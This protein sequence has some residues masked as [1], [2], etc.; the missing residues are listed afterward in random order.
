[1]AGREGEICN[2][3]QL[4]E[5][6]RLLSFCHWEKGRGTANSR[7]WSERSASMSEANEGGHYF[8]YFSFFFLFS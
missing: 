5:V 8:C 1:M 6:G 3:D 4:R 7:F 2:V